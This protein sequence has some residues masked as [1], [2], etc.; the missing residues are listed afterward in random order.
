MFNV[1]FFSFLGKFILPAEFPVE[2][3]YDI[4]MQ[5]HALDDLAFAIEFKVK[6]KKKKFYLKNKMD[7]L[8]VLRV[9]QILKNYHV[10]QLLEQ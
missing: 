5:K 7:L 6:E 3:L 2:Q 1:L 4:Y 10:H 9:S 8:F